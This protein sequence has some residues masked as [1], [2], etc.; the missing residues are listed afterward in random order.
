MAEPNTLALRN[1]SFEQEV[2]TLQLVSRMAKQSGMYKGVGD[3]AQIFMI[4]LA[5]KELGITPTLA[6]NKGIN[7]IKGNIELS[8]RLM[9]LMIRRAGHS[10]EIVETSD[11]VCVLKGT[12]KDNADT[13]TCKFT[14]EDA[15]KAGITGNDVWKKYAEDMLYARAL[16]RLARRLYADVIGGA[17]IEGEI[18]E[19][20]EPE[21]TIGVTCEKV[22]E[23]KNIVTEEMEKELETLLLQ[24]PNIKESSDAYMGKRGLTRL[25]EIEF[26]DFNRYLKIAKKQKEKVNDT[27]TTA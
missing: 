7:I 14:I 10:I 9:S 18:S 11:K 3:E 20:V 4:L 16:S 2:Q 15:I 27:T 8:A 26:N 1:S 23:D 17:Y 19:P 13:C 12:R 6:L 24:Y 21:S 25:S 22:E 5:A